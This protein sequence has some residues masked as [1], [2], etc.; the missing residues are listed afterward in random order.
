MR[1][2]QG[3]ILA[4]TL[5][6][7]G[8]ILAA[9][10]SMM[11]ASVT[12]LKSV[13]SSNQSVNAFQIADSGSQVMLKMLK[14][15]T[16]TKLADMIAPASCPIGQDAT[17]NQTN[18]LGGSY[19][20]TFKDGDGNT[21]KCSDNTSEVASVKSV[22]TYRNTARAVE[23]A[24]LQTAKLVGWW[25]LN[26]GSGLSAV[27]ETTNSNDGTLGVLDLPVWQNV[28]PDEFLDFNGADSEVSIS[29]DAS[30]D[31]KREISISLWFNADNLPPVGS[32]A[33]LVSKM[34]NNGS[35]SSR[36]YSVW[37]NNLGFVH[38][39]SS[40]A[41]GTESC[42]DTEDSVVAAGSWHHYVGVIDRNAGAMTLYLDGS[43][44]DP[45][46]TLHHCAGGGVF[47]GG[48]DALQNNEPVK[49]GGRF[50]VFSTFDG[51]IDD[52]RIYDGILTGVEVANLY[53][54]GSGRE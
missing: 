36:S 32:W 54:S 2:S 53:G 12:N 35:E 33:P 3:S 5:I 43:K 44:K 8:I 39:T 9:S 42:T 17:V 41:A 52:V 10:I 4:Y 48:E 30:L 16:E 34:D 26:D 7:L 20:V 31:L 40:S 37:L 1:T 49:I 46:T 25:K 11:A 29:D 22:G 28:S 47:P 27:D 14:E 21:L 23:V 45:G 19:R 38:L 50:G 51:Q 24:V 13:S 15:T 18:F 6:L